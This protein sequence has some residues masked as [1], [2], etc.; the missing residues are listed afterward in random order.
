MIN[1]PGNRKSLFGQMHLGIAYIASYLEKNGIKS[2]I[3]DCSIHDY[4]IKNIMEDITKE[5]YDVIG[6]TAYFYNY[7]EIMR[8]VFEI[9]RK[10]PNAFLFLEGYLPS[11]NYMRMKNVFTLIDCLI[12][13]EGEVTTLNIIN[14][15]ENG[16]WKKFPG[17][18][19]LK[20][21]DVFFTGNAAL[22]EELDIFPPPKIMRYL[23]VMPIM[24]IRGCCG[25]CTFCCSNA[26]RKVCDGCYVRRRSP[27]NVIK[28]IVDLV[29]HGVKRIQICDSTFEIVSPKA[30]YWFDE[31]SG[32]IKEK[33]VKCEFECFFRV[34]DIVNQAERIRM[35][36]GM[37]L[38][39]IFVG[40]E[41]FIEEHLAYY[42]KGTTVEK[43]IQA[44]Q[45][46]D[47]MN[48]SYDI[49]FIL[50]NPITTVNDVLQ[51]AKT[52]KKINF[53]RNKWVIHKTVS[54][55]VLAAFPGTHLCTTIEEK[56][57][58]D[59][60]KKGF[61]FIYNRVDLCFSLC[62]QWGQRIQEIYDYRDF[63][64]ELFNTEQI[65]LEEKMKEIFYR[66][67]NIDINFL[68]ELSQAII[69]HP[70]YTESDF[71]YI[72]DMHA[73]CLQPLICWVKEIYEAYEVSSANCKLDSGAAISTF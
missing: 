62:Q 67:F 26:F 31:F 10:I 7:K 4:S 37:G 56:H 11:L 15:L 39:H 51:T 38:V 35:F 12:V 34:D 46:L 3:I 23:D 55:S 72:I 42:N 54:N 16:D 65:G 25:E 18:A 14:N 24:T 29:E 13:G 32:L 49:G 28:E 66:A 9:K 60:S 57:L 73:Q 40:I 63:Y 19:Y 48:L 44:L 17:I 6:L 2:N 53:N 59:A 33:N 64:L 58:R 47:D 20:D 36:M 41:S 71:I 30:Q 8:L 43:N 50:F 69:A 70:D 5:V 52:F 45:I 22:V 68:E 1:L 27:E 61:R 21:D